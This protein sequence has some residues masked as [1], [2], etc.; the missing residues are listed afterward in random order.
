[1]KNIKKLLVGGVATALLLGSAVT[2]YAVGSNGSFE[3]GTNPGSITTLTAV[4]TTNI[5]D[6]KVAT[7]NIDYIGSYWQAADGVR[8]VDLSGNTAGSIR[9]TLTTVVG[10]TYKVTFAMAGNPDGGPVVK[11]L[12]AD[13]GGAPIPF[14]FDVTGHDKTNM[15]WES[16]TFNFTAT[17][18]STVLTFTST[19]ATAFGPALDKVVVEDTTSV[20]PTPSAIPAECDQS[21][22]YNV[23]EG[24]GASEIINGTNG[25]DLIL[26]KG[27][28]DIVNGKGGN[29]CI[30]GGDGSDSLKGGS[31]NDVILGGADSDA[32]DGEEGN[33]KLYG[34]GGSDAIKGGNDNDDLFGGA[35]ADSLQGNAGTDTAD[36]GAGTD[37]CSAETQTACNP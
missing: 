1:M 31:G 19:T 28:S 16:K 13:T 32:I 2:I 20:T 18:T 4:D 29:D 9:Q 6:W 37:A 7:G 35:A 30:V 27:G 8:S 23:I 17:G 36:G 14:T 33:D 15:G 26:A 3:L 11:T 22:T 12:N 21:L 5:T 10:H 24:T 25:H 34:E